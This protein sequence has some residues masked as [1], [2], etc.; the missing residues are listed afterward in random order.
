MSLAI[1]SDQ[2]SLPLLDPS[3]GAT[4]SNDR[5]PGSRE[6]VWKVLGSAYY[7]PSHGASD[8]VLSEPLCLRGSVLRQ[9]PSGLGEAER[10]TTPGLYPHF[11]FSKEPL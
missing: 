9:L 8:H 4:L 1:D 6:Q 2:R 3:R 7:S 10:T 5:A 11:N